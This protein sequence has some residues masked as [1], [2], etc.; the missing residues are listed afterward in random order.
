MD[1]SLAALTPCHLAFIAYRSLHRLFEQHPRLSGVF[2]RVMLI[3]AA[4]F[5]EW[6]V[7]IGRRQAPARMAHLLC[8]LFL[9]HN[10]KELVPD[11]AFELPITQNELADA[12]GYRPCM[13]TAPCRSYEPRDSWASRATYLKIQDWA[14]LKQAGEFDPTSSTRNLMARQTN[15]RQPP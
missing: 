7:N 11:H 5:R 14:G 3:G 4:I 13:S 9:R 15:A 2:W 1:H 8:E 12:L 6:V 10:A